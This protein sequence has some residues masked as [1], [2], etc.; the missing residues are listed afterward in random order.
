MKRVVTRF[1]GVFLLL[2]LGF[3]VSAQDTS[4]HERKKKDLENEINILQSQIKKNDARSKDLLEKFSLTE[5]LLSTRRSLLNESN[6]QIRVLDQRI[7]V[8]RKKA[9]E[10]RQ[11]VDTLDKYYSRLLVSAYKSRHMDSW[12]VYILSSKSLGQAYR[13]YNYFKSLSDNL[14]SQAVELKTAR[15][16]LQ[17]ELDSLSILRNQQQQL[18]AEHQQA[19]NELKKEEKSYKSTISSLKRNRQKYTRQINRKRQEMAKLD[20]EIERIINSAMKGS[21]K[22]SPPPIDYALD[23]EFSKN[24]GKLPWPVQGTVVERYGQ[25]FHPV[26][27]HVKMPFNK[28]IN[29]AVK[30][31]EVAKAVF[32]GVVTQVVVIPGYNLCVMLRHGNYFTF[33]CKLKSTVVKAGDKVKTGQ[34]LG[35]VDTVSGSTRLHFEVWQGNKHQ[36]PESWLR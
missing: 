18:R 35:R 22:K 33:Y 19:Y 14:K 32:D 4:Q 13:R 27:K 26:F 28:G 1:L 9:E 2:C 23:G 25:R 11:R 10:I 16:E 17:Q 5:K 30:E 8:R 24:K 34:E 12:Y 20:R 3:S 36:N 7:S 15:E 29:I 6:H 31:G 21:G